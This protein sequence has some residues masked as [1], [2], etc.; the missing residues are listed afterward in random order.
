MIKARLPYPTDQPKA[1]SRQKPLGKLRALKLVVFGYGAAL[2]PVLLS[3]TGWDGDLT[4][5]LDAGRW[6]L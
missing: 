4:G 1:L 5:N 2:C 6:F 3:L